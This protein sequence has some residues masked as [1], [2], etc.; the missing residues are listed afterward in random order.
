MIDY[1]YNGELNY[2]KVID[3]FAQIS[4]NNF[5]GKDHISLNPDRKK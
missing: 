4:H 5:Y 1:Q 2:K 3:K